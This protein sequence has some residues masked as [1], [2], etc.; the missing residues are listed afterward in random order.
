M[1]LGMWQHLHSFADLFGTEDVQGG[2]FML[3][4]ILC[5]GKVMYLSVEL[6]ICSQAQYS[7]FPLYIPN[8]LLFMSV[9]H[10]AS[11]RGICGSLTGPV[12]C[13]PWHVSHHPVDFDAWECGCPGEVHATLYPTERRQ[14][15]CSIGVS[16]LPLRFTLKLLMAQKVLAFHC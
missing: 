4:K 12:P 5:R 7:F 2:T 1:I 11:M 15:W 10:R 16:A 6:G 3:E 8:I 13:C 14:R 9:N